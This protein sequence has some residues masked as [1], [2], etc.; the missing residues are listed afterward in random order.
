MAASPRS[1]PFIAAPPSPSFGC[2][3]S[4]ARIRSPGLQ[5]KRA[6]AAMEKLRVKVCLQAPDSKAVTPPFAEPGFMPRQLPAPPWSAKFCSH[7]SFVP[8][9]SPRAG[10]TAPRLGIRD[11]ILLAPARERRSQTMKLTLKHAVAAIFLVLSFA[12][13]LA[14]GP[15]DFSK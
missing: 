12:S 14:A 3:N 5:R 11:I 2:A 8:F 15:N 4:L 9:A 7:A 13:Q 6:T 10:S 1:K